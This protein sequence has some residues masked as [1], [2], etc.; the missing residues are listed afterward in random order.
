MTTG[1]L[2]FFSIRGSDLEQRF[3]ICAINAT[4]D[5]YIGGEKLALSADKL[6]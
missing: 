4:T 1:E 2:G 6:T 5:S 3:S